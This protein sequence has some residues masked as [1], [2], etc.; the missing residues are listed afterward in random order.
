MGT[1]E[2][3]IV[4]EIGGLVIAEDGPLVLVIDRGNGPLAIMAF[5]TGVVALV[6]GGFGAVGLAAMA[7]GHGGGLPAWLC[8]TLLGVGLVSAGITG[9]V[10]RRIG[11]SRLIPV[12]QYRPVAVFDRAARVYRDADGRPIAPLDAVS[13]H[14]RMQMGSSSLKLV[15]QTPDA[16]YTLVR[17]NPFIGGLGDLAAV[18]TTAVHG[19]PR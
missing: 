2:P 9:G 14:R 6:F 4:R 19:A 10:V 12:N 11:A 16:A 3:H 7:T 8:A 1:R 17:G 5:V 13:F 18:L 15:A